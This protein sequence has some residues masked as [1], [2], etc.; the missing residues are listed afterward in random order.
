MPEVTQLESRAART[1]TKHSDSRAYTPGFFRCINRDQRSPYYGLTMSGEA[2]ISALDATSR[3]MDT[4]C[5]SNGRRGR[6]PRGLA[7]VSRLVDQTLLYKIHGKTQERWRGRKHRQGE[8]GGVCCAKRF[9]LYPGY[10]AV[11]SV[12]IC[13][14]TRFAHKNAHT[15]NRSDCRSYEV[16][17][18]GGAIRK[19]LL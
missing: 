9:G 5:R 7:A 3:R 18:W 10:H 8:T 14:L 6:W 13:L 17:D 15:G 12:W 11:M 16:E 1:G 2:L 4:H 19:L